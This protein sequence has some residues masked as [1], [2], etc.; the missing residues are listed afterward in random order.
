MLPAEFP[1][2]L[3]KKPKLRGEALVFWA[4][5]A[6]LDER[7]WV[8]YDR[9]IPDSRRR[10]DFLCANPD[11]GIF[12]IECKGGMVHD[13]R[14]SFRQLV[15]RKPVWRK[16]IDPFGQL[17]L[18][19]R[20]LFAAAGVQTQT[21]PLHQAIWFPEMGQGGLRWQPSPHILTR[22]ILQTDKLIELIDAVLPGSPAVGQSE[23]VG[24]VVATLVNRRRGV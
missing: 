7:W 24:Q 2:D 13:K 17:K 6:A 23:R 22:E 5:S 8:L 11:R 19:L 14:G 12:A 3:D 20:D 18:A 16:K 9:P 10:V 15:S 21:L 4:L 1:H